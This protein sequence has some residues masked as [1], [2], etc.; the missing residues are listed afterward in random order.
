MWV[1]ITKESI[2]PYDI[3]SV[4]VYFNYKCGSVEF[5]VPPPRLL[6]SVTPTAVTDTTPVS[7]VR[8]FFWF[9]LVNHLK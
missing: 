7:H 4:Q 9:I 8:E 6:D 5:V 1:Y 2:D 3:E